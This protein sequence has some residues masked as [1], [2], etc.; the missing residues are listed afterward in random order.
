MIME[1]RQDIIGLHAYDSLQQ[2]RTTYHLTL[3]TPL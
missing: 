1:I 2:Q 3:T